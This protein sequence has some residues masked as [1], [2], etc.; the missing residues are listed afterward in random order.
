MYRIYRYSETNLPYKHISLKRRYEVVEKAEAVMHEM[1]LDNSLSR[2]RRLFFD[3]AMCNRFDLF[4]TFTFD[5]ERYNSM[6]YQEVK[7]KLTKWFNNFVT[8]HDPQFRYMLIPEKHES[9]AWHFHGLCTLPVGMCTPLKIPKREGDRVEYVLNTKHYLSWPAA[10]D[11]FGWFSAS[12]IEDYAKTVNYCTKYITKALSDKNMKHARLLLKSKG[13]NKPEVVY[14]SYESMKLRPDYQNE[15]CAIAWCDEI[16][17]LPYYKHW[18]CTEGEDVY[19]MTPFEMP[20][21]QGIE[22]MSFNINKPERG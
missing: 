3:Y 17:T 11:K 8:R 10:S 16:D 14:A 20:C 4:V 22:Q 5:P 7:A 2:T 13:L 18:S 1:R 6:D 15:F 12:Y 9:G 21:P 19:Q